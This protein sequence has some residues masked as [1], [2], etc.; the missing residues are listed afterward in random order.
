[1]NDTALNAAAVLTTP[2]EPTTGERRPFERDVALDN[3]GPVGFFTKTQPWAD[4][5]ADWRAGIAEERLV[6]VKLPSLHNLRL[7]SRDG[8]LCRG[9]FAP[10]QSG[11]GLAYTPHAWSQLIGLLKAK[12]AQPGTANV[13][14]WLTPEPRHYAFAD[15]I[16]RSM[17]PQNEEAVLRTFRVGNMCALRAVVSG[18]HALTA[19]DDANVLT[20]MEESFSYLSKVD[21]RGSVSRGW[22]MTRGHVS[23]PTGGDDLRIGFNF[24]NSE[25]GCA[26]L[27]FSASLTISTLDAII[28]MPE[29]SQRER[30]ISVLSAGGGSR[31]RHTTPRFDGGYRLSEETREIIA[32]RRVAGDLKSVLATSSQLGAAW[33]KALTQVSNLAATGGVEVVEDFLMERGLDPA[34]VKDVGVVLRDDARLMKLPR[35]SVAHVTAAIAV[36]AR[37]KDRSWED[38]LDIQEQAGRFLLQGWGK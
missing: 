27:K 1:M 4:V 24:V 6:D 38:S 26:S 29:G 2:C 34:L 15:V 17:R 33:A 22:N 28:S 25:T 10:G 21:V 14:R 30:M 7:D 20:A 19:F 12:E 3:K 18:R 32:R 16:R 35:G 8:A 31:R 5:A 36:A 11:G 23:L 9:T 37:L 13:L